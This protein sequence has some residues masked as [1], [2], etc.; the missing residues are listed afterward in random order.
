MFK[1][2]ANRSFSKTG[3]KIILIAAIVLFIALLIFLLSIPKKKPVEVQEPFGEPSQT[4]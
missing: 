4:K 3:R 2:V 1:Q